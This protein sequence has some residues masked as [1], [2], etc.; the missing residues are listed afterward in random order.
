[1]NVTEDDCKAIVPLWMLSMHLKRH[2]A[3]SIGK[4]NG[5]KVFEESKTPVLVKWAEA[6]AVDR[7]VNGLLPETDK[8]IGYAKFVQQKSGCC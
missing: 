2:F 4:M 8:L 5:K 1:M 3:E 7:A 6:F